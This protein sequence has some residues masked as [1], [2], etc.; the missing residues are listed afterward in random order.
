MTTV[1]LSMDPDLAIDPPVAISRPMMVHKWTD[2]A[3][4][5]WPFEAELV[6]RL[7]PNSLEVDSFDGAAW[8]GLIPFHLEVRCPAWVASLPKISRTLEV[9]AR[10]YVRGPD[11]RRGI[12][13]LSLDAECLPVVLTA[14]YWYRIP[15]M[16]A[17]LSF[18]KTDANVIYESR[19]RFPN[20]SDAHFRMNLG[21]ANELITP[22]PLEQFLSCRWRLYSPARDGIM[23]SQIEHPRWP[24]LRSWP[25]ETDAG[26]LKTFGLEADGPPLTMFSP[27]V[28]VRWEPRH[29]AADE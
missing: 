27:G 25:I 14:R 24:I 21:I 2:L 7:L 4:L 6:Q 26:L 16:W 1:E 17:A 3:M 19:R 11:G 18:Q 22:S 23:S 15:Y 8:V 29:F 13:F 20:N 10:T 12:W 5:H 28:T 9:N